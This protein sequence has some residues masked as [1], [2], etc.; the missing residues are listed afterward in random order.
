MP[1]DTKDPGSSKNHSED[2]RESVAETQ[3]EEFS[4]QNATLEE[5]VSAVAHDFRSPLLA[6]TGYCQLLEE[7]YGDQLP[8]AARQYVHRIMDGAHRL[9]QMIED[10]L[11]SSKTG[12]ASRS[13]RE[14]K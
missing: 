8:S 5:F 4:R 3:E 6:I 12:R 11:R 10:M 9:D 14:P 7:D 2:S 13:V 1:T